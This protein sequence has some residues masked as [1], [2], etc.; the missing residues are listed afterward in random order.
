MTY[1]NPRL[2]HLR[3]PVASNSTIRPCGG[4]GTNEDAIIDGNQCQCQQG[5]VWKYLSHR[6]RSSPSSLLNT[7]PNLQIQLSTWN[8]HL[9][10]LMSCGSGLLPGWVCF[11]YSAAF[12]SYRV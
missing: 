5:Y 3:Q 11:W 4:Q 8:V 2:P 1:S 7:S 9:I 6:R 12:P 10:S